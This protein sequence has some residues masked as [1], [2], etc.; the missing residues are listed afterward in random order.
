[1]VV[2][3][4]AVVVVDGDVEVV[5][6]PGA[7]VV[8]VVGKVVEVS[9]IGLVFVTSAPG[10]PTVLVP[11]AAASRQRL[12]ITAAERFIVSP[13]RNINDACP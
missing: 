3:G 1:M 13:F 6:V 11:Q 10:G 8:V 7:A 12:R 4:G 5:V 9:D 2:A